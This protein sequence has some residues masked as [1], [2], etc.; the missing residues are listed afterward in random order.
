MW[1][2]TVCVLLSINHDIYH[3][4]ECGNNALCKNQF[5]TIFFYVV[6]QLAACLCVPTL[7]SVF[8]NLHI[9]L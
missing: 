6:Y 7:D 5:L 8:Y 4:I 1:S 3:T 9:T 2:M